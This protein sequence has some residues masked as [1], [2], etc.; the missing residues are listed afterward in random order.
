[1]DTGSIL[2][3]DTVLIGLPFSKVADSEVVLCDS[4]V[5]ALEPAVVIPL[6]CAIHFPLHHVTNNLATTIIEWHGPA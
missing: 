4:G 6:I 2:G 3:N 1:M 5:V